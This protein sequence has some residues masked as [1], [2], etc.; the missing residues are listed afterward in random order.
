MSKFD[1][2][3]ALIMYVC[4][5]V[6]YCLYQ[7]GWILDLYDA[8]FTDILYFLVRLL[9]KIYYLLETYVM[10]KEVMHYIKHNLSNEKQMDCI[11]YN[12]VK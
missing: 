10:T 6:L 9:Y 11:K 3:S 4:D 7:P 8:T 1:V 2:N 12:V 5:A